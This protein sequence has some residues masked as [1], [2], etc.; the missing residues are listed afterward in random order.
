MTA[1]SHDDAYE[2]RLAAQ[3]LSNFASVAAGKIALDEDLRISEWNIDC[4]DQMGIGAEWIAPLGNETFYELQSSGTIL[5]VLGRIERGYAS[6][7]R[8]AVEDNPSITTVALG[9]GGGFVGE[10]IEA[11]LFL[12]SRDISTVLWNNC[13]SA[14]PLVFAGGKER[15]ID[16]PYPSLGFHQIATDEGAVPLDSEPYVAVA[17]YLLQM[18]VSPDYVL[19]KMMAAKPSEMYEVGGADQELCESGLVT[20]IRRV[21]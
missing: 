15:G 11:G 21:C 7:I 19:Q 17:S 8:Q 2:L 4:V 20:W 1:L 3:S 12:R 18:G 10:A 14:C 6:K 16:S 5:R 9:S 13:Y